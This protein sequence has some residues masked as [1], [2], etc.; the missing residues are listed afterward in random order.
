MKW[1]EIAITAGKKEFLPELTSYTGPQYEFE[2]RINA[3]TVLKRLR[4]TSDVILSNALAASQHWNGKLR[5]AAK[6]YLTYFGK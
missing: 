2:T 1:L 3:F 5:D 6:E 4:Y